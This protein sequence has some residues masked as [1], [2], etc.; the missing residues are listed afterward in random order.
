[1]DANKRLQ[2]LLDERGWTYYRLAKN[3]GLSEST[4]A[5]IFLR[6]TIPSLSTLE[7][8]CRGFGITL[9]Q[10]FSDG[11]D[12]PLTS[13]AREMLDAWGML[14][15]NQRAVLLQVAKTMQNQ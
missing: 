14:S 13:E 2:E 4:L 7:I 6:G 10:F 3:T 9:A 12:L 8:I 15:P 11:D 1:M 5:N